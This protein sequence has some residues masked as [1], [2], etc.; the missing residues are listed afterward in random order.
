MVLVLGVRAGL[1]LP[2]GYLNLLVH[3]TVKLQLNELQQTLGKCSLK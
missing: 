3:G 1:R 2:H